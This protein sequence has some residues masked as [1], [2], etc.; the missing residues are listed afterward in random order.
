MDRRLRGSPRRWAPRSVALGPAVGV[1]PL[2]RLARY[3]THPPTQ[4]SGCGV[5]I[6]R[7]PRHARGRRRPSAAR[8]RRWARLH[9]R[10]RPASQRST[11]ARF[12][13]REKRSPRGSHRCPARRRAPSAAPGAGTPNL[14]D[15]PQPRNLRPAFMLPRLSSRAGSSSSSRQP[16]DPGWKRAGP[17]MM[18]AGLEGRHVTSRTRSG[19]C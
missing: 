15:L 1:A 6:H 14:G 17:D 9:R 5:A 10:G 13:L 18:A 19:G 4:R 11:K 7:A 2:C 8:P 16:V 3:P 12:R